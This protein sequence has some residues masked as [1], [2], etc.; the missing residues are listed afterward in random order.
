MA[1]FNLYLDLSSI[2]STTAPA[3]EIL[4]DGEVVSSLSVSSGFTNTTLSLSYSGDAPNYLSFRFND[5]NGEVDRSITLN[6][7]RI[8]GTPVSGGSLS[9]GVLLQGQESQLNISAEQPS[10]GIASPPSGVDAIINGTAGADNLRG[11]TGDDTINGFDGIDYIRAGNGNDTINAGADHDVVKGGLGNDTINGDDGNDLLKGEW[12]DDTINGGEGNDTLDGS[13]GVDALNGGN[14]NDVLKGGA[15][16][17]TLHG[18]GGNDILRGGDDGD[19][20]Y[21]DAGNDKLEG[22]AGNDTLYGG[23]GFDRLFGGDGNDILDG[24]GDSD[25]LYGEAG[26]DTLYGRGGFDLLI[27]GAGDDTIFGGDDNDTLHGD[28]GQDIL[29]GEDGNDRLRGG[30]DNDILHGDAGSDTLIGDAGNDT[31]HGGIGN[32][33]LEGGIGD[34]VLNGDAGNDNLYGQEGNDTMNGGDGNDF[35]FGKTGNDTLNGGIGDDTLEGGLDND[36]INGGDGADIIDGGGDLDT[37]NGGAGNDTIYGDGSIDRAA[38]IDAILVA[39]PSVV[40]NATTDSFYQHVTTNLNFFDARA[41]AASTTLNGVGGYLTNITSAAENTFID[42][43]IVADTWIGASDSGVEGVWEWMDGDEAGQQFWAGAAA[44][45]SVGGFY[46]NWAGGEPND[47]GTGEDYASIRTNGTWNDLRGTYSRDSM[48]EWEADRVLGF[49]TGSND[50]INGGDGDDTIY[51]DFSTVATDGQGW[52]YQYYD[53]ATS[54]S[55]LAGAGFTLNGGKDNTNT[56]TASGITQDFEPSNFDGGDN[57]ALKYTT[58]LTIT[59]T[60]TYTF[61]TASD[62]GSKL[63]LDGVEI[64]TNDG[65]HGT[66]TITSAGQS[67]TA[68]TY[69]LEAVYFERTGGDTMNVLMAGPDTGGGYV[70]LGTYGAVSAGK[71]GSTSDG[72]DTIAGGAGT[73]I[74]YGGGGLDVFV[75]EAASAYTETDSI[76]DFS[77]IEGDAIDISDLISSFSGTISDYVQLTISGSDTIVSV[78]GNGT[79]GGVSFQNVAIIDS[80]V[81]LD[82]A[83]LYADGQIIV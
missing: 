23:V 2:Y 1:T 69:T 61:R 75:F 67:L 16:I 21:G 59:T 11:T 43:L 40:Y 30:D 8:N 51:G 7:V 41:N 13:V 50:I 58:T 22:N 20:L 38:E 12:G 73:D 68:G 65:L 52:F 76:M 15:G 55:N 79:T 36:I 53:L 39:N 29:R 45:S 31:L 62:D 72:D 44:G 27:G 3:F 57:F 19:F 26:N 4:L 10:F 6:E 56:A 60:G 25:R 5:N 47:Y 18:D 37:I 64:V 9:K 81:G 24:E 77:I 33:L 74:L 71:A 78:D 49:T 35:L 34:D 80:E 48:I 42:G 70:G 14:G 82:L 66:V 28:A 63:F 83:T 46:E 32:D 54:P 17:D